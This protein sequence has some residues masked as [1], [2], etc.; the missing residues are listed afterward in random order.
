MKNFITLAVLG[1]LMLFIT[2]FSEAQTIKVVGVDELPVGAIT[3]GTVMA[4][5]FDIKNKVTSYQD[6]YNE[7]DGSKIENSEDYY[8]AYF[9][10][11]EK[12]S[13]DTFGITTC[14]LTARDYHKVI[15]EQAPPIEFTLPKNERLIVT[16]VRVSDTALIFPGV[17]VMGGS[18]IAL[19]VYTISLTDVNKTALVQITCTPGVGLR[20]RLNASLKIKNMKNQFRSHFSKFEFN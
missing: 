7:D 1:S 8:S 5:D 9:A 17:G 19:S 12:S 14:K 2:P 15:I 3:E 6:K 10:G 4:F 16:N 13:N 20:Y 18:D 11:G